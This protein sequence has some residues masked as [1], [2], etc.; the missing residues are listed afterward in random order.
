MTWC[1]AKDDISPQQIFDKHKYGGSKGRAE[2]AKY[3]I[4]DC[5]LV[6]IYYYNWTL[7]PNNIGMASVSWVP[8]SYI[9]LRGQGIKINS[10]ITKVCSEK[11]H[12]FQHWLVLK[13]D[14]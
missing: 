1:L 12:V 9:F 13:T 2:V 6:F 10:I 8:I 7:Y 4:M 3:C 11:K 5:E 14:K